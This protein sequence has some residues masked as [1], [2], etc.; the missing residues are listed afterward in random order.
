MPAMSSN[1]WFSGDFVIVLMAGLVFGRRT[2]DAL[3]QHLV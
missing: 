1:S 2:Q 3:P